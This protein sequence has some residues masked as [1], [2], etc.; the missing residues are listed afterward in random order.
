MASRL[1]RRDFLKLAALLPLTQLRWPLLV[2]EPRGLAQNA[3]APNVLFLVFDTLTAHDVSLYGYHRET[4]PNLARFA[5][6]ATVF[7][8]H[9]AGANFTSPGTATLLTG[10]YPWTHRAMQL[11][12]LTESQFVNKNIFALFGQHGYFQTAYTHNPLAMG[13]LL[14]FRE[15]LDA[16]IPARELTLLDEQFSDLLLMNDW[17]NS[18]DVEWQYVRGGLG[19]YPP[20][21]L[22]LSWLHRLVRLWDKRKVTQALGDQFPL[23]IP[24]NNSSFFILEEAID[25]IQTQLV[26][27][28][29]PF[30]AYVHLLPPH[31]PYAPRKDFVGLFSDDFRPGV[32]TADTKPNHPLVG[33]G[34]SPSQLVKNRRDYD[35]FLA[36]TDSEFGRLLDYMEQNGV[37]D[38]T[39]VVFTSDHGESFERGVL[40]H[41]TPILYETLLRVPLLISRP[42]QQTREDI[43]TP[44]SNV[45][46]LPTLLHLT[47]QPIPDW[48]EGQVLPPFGEAD[49]A[50]AVFAVEAKSNPKLAPLTRRATITMV[51]E[52]VKLIHYI[53]YPNLGPAYELYNLA[54]DP[55]ELNNL[56]TS[57]KSLAAAMQDE[58]QEKLN[59]VNLPYQ[60]N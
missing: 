28:P 46:I 25:W 17:N 21:S 53:G 14:E 54:E 22:F 32:P 38:N 49:E 3:S 23:G 7:H 43:F 30:L 56:Y 1:T 20:G 55:E 44:T 60:R 2:G 4:T 45:D 8:N 41:L 5:E 51:K 33:G 11:Q 57:D 40:G 37:L 12:G 48:V 35:E 19:Q 13:L 9:R 29:Q 24:N 27:L 26:T 6:R 36:Y 47:G 10:T 16:F 18:Y 42:G 59:Q 52:D 39:I 15:S 31:G 34:V 58:L 50:R